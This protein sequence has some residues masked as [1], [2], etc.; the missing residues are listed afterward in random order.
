M[1]IVS[2]AR[3]LT[4]ARTNLILFLQKPIFPPNSL[5]M[6][7]TLFL[8][9]F[10]SCVCVFR[11]IVEFSGK[12][13]IFLGCF[14]LTKF[15]LILI[16]NKTIKFSATI[17]TGEVSKKAPNWILVQHQKFMA[18]VAIF[19]QL[20]V[21]IALVLVNKIGKSVNIIVFVCIRSL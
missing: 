8:C 16:A 19:L 21:E 3:P 5:F 10:Y 12:S 6:R 17:F 11:F 14:F 18:T 20:F 15:N 4:S 7:K 2:I 9:L 1:R 13:F